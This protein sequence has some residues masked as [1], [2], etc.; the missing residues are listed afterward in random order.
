MSVLVL[1]NAA[2]ALAPGYRWLLAA[3]VL[4]ALAGGLYSPI[5]LAAAVEVSAPSE[6]ARAVAVALG[7]LTISLVIGVPLG[8][9]LG[10]LGSWR[11]T[12]GFA[13]AAAAA[14]GIHASLPSLPAAPRASLAVRVA[15]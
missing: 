15:L 10:N 1:A 8:S 14:C 5:A 11:W 4:A 7:G 13:T 3:R 2:A 12:F 6:R 9:L